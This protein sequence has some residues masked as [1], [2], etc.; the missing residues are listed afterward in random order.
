[1]KKA[2][3]ELKTFLILW[4][5]QSLSQLGSAMTSFALTL[6]LYEKTGSAL[7]TA[8]LS[9]CSYGPYVLMS[10]FAG[11]LCDRWDKKRTM[12]V[13]DGLAACCS[14]AVLILLRLDALRAAHLYVLN[15][16]TGLMNTVQSPA[17]DVAMTLITPKAQY[18]RT[19]ALRSFSGSL[20][21]IL[22]PM[23][24]TALFA[25]A[26][27][28]GVIYVDLSTFAAAALTLALFVRIPAAEPD[29]SDGESL[30]TGARA[31]LVYLRRNGL[32]LALILFMAGVNF[33]A[34]ALDA[35]L[36]A[37][38]LSSPNGGEKALGAVSSCAGLATLA[39]SVL[40][41]V[42]PPPRNRVRVIWWTTLFSLCTE[43]FI[44]AFAGAPVWWCLAQVAGWSVVPVMNANLDVILRGTIPPSMQGRVYSCRNTLQFFTIPLGLFA[45][46][47]LVDRVCGPLTADPDGALARLFGAGGNPGAALTMFVLGVLGVVVC[48]A[49]A[50][51]LRK[52]TYKE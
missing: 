45:G 3:R 13:C 18:Q 22:N 15:A 7:S 41:A 8:L 25:L 27:M 32:I 37:Y 36:P 38:V 23:L 33:V 52:Y 4:S 1:M 47:F 20:V 43:N 39:G 17:S 34:S 14:A 6:W 26:G 48:L 40:A 5:T 11:T 49:F 19:S 12:L 30:L 21:T 35:A 29:R 16:V 42:L 2:Y 10:V 46:G 24:A 9:I 50:R 31:G 44:L 28:E 51:T